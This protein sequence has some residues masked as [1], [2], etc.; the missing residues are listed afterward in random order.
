[1]ATALALQLQSFQW[2]FRVSLL[3]DGL[4]GAPCSPGT[5][6]SLLQRLVVV[7]GLPLAAAS[8]AGTTGSGAHGPQEWPQRGLRASSTGSLLVVCGLSRSAARGICPD[9]GSNPS[10]LCLLHRQA[11]SSPLSHQGGPY[12]GVLPW[13]SRGRLSPE[14]RIPVASRCSFCLSLSSTPRGLGSEG[15]RPAE[16]ACF[17]GF[18][19]V[20]GAGEG[21]SCYCSKG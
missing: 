14:E 21:W 10:L 2:L 6:E 17:P 8:L 15:A 20:V 3:E 5:L 18:Y 9:Q 1:M 7:R 11:N 12:K 16:P 13:L 19:A 4:V